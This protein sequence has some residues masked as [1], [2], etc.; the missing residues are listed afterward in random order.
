MEVSAEHCAM[1]PDMAGCE[2]F[3]SPNT[4]DNSMM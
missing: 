3:N 4:Q 2:K 1:M